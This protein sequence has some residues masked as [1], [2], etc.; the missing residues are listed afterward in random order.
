MQTCP[1]ADSALF[2]CSHMPEIGSEGLLQS[3][4][5][6][7]P[8][9]EGLEEF[10]VQNFDPGMPST[11]EKGLRTNS[12]M[13]DLG[14]GAI[15]GV[16]RGFMCSTHDFNQRWKSEVYSK[17]PGVTNEFIYKMNVYAA[18]IG[19]PEGDLEEGPIADIWTNVLQ[20]SNLLLGISYT[21]CLQSNL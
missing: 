5:A 17:W 2:A 15:L 16:Y 9:A 18:D 13:S 11:T 21:R 4:P 6:Y 20:V 7:M 1:V 19:K 14:P 12:E 3:L 8:V 10:I